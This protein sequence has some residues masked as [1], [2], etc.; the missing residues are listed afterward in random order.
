MGDYPLKHV[1]SPVELTN[2][3]FGPATKHEELRDEIYC[4]IM[5][6]MTN[7]SNRSPSVPQCAERKENHTKSASI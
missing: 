1:R 6:Q 2:Q 3:I 4:Q 5:R 7:N